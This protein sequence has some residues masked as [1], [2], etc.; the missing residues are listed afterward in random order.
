MWNM[1]ATR[2]DCR[3]IGLHLDYNKDERRDEDEGEVKMIG[4]RIKNRISFFCI[5]IF[6]LKNSKKHNIALM[7]S[8]K[9]FYIWG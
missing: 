6:L 9:S 8:I 2:F 3:S 1:D 7:H 5:H 4:S